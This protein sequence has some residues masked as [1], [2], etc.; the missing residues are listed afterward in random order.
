VVEHK[1]ALL[2]DLADECALLADGRVVVSGP[3]A[4]VL[5]DERLLELGVEPPPAVRLRRAAA[6]RG[7]AIDPAILEGVA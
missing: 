1:T 7:L 5:A 4:E 3:T 2:A 6:A